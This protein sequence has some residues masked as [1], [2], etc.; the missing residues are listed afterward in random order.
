MKAPAFW[1]EASGSR[2]ASLLGPV[3]ALYDLAGRLTR[4]GK[5]PQRCRAKV[6]CVGNLVAGG[7]GKTPVSLALAALLDDAGIAFLTRGYGGRETGPLRVDTNGHTARDVGDEALLLARAAPTWVARNRPAGARAAVTSG[8]RTIIMDDGFQNP[9]LHKDI[10][11]VVVDGATGFGNGRVMPAGPLRE[12]VPDG[13]ARADAIVIV[14][15]DTAGIAAGLTNPFPV[16]QGQL[17]TG[18]ESTSLA[19][20]RVLTFAGIGRPQKFFDTLRNMGCE[21]VGS[22]E[23]ADH[24]PYTPEQIMKLCEDAAALDAVPVTTEKDLVR[25][26]PEARAMV[27]SVPVTLQWTDPDAV[28]SFLNTKLSR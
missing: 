22:R 5:H 10:S 2:T 7:A 19:G 6:I 26:P 11:L 24:Q 18:P 20:R 27:T 17:V 4:A 16:F 1:Y 14:G 21:I 15:D 9:S 25:L 12:T 28:R 23:F 8:A 3:A 13:L